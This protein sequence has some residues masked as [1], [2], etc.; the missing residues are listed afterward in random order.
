MKIIALIF[1]LFTTQRAS[2][3]PYFEGEIVYALAYTLKDTTFDLNNIGL[4]PSKE[5]TTLFKNGNWLTLP[6]EGPL[7]YIYQDIVN[8][9]YY[10]KYRGIDTIY[11]MSSGPGYDI[12]DSILR[13]EQKKQTDTILGRLC[14]RVT[15]HTRKLKLTMLYNR[16]LAANLQLYLKSAKGFYNIIYPL[17]KAYYLQSIADGEKVYSTM[18]ATSVK[19]QQLPDDFFPDLSLY[20]HV[21]L[22]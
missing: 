15:F 1:F 4:Y 9:M 10:E 19:W 13:I 11:F 7:K 3:Q 16:E 14:D 5:V 2:T 21:K 12:Q 6:P 22:H 20:P 17:T 8:N 18:T